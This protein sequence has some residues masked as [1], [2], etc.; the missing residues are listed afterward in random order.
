[1]LGVL[2][3]VGRG[4]FFGVKLIW[5]KIEKERQAERRAGKEK[6]HAESRSC[7]LQCYKITYE[8]DASVESHPCRRLQDVRMPIL[9]PSDH[10]SRWNVLADRLGA[11]ASFLCALHCALLPLVV[12]MLPA[13]GLG[14]LADHRFE[15]GF[16]VFAAVLA[17]VSLWLGYRRHQ[18]VHAFG[19]FVPGIVLLLVGAQLAVDEP[20]HL[21]AVLVTIGGSLVA[22]AHVANLWLAQRHVHDASC[23]H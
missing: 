9:E 18:R 8:P 13:L 10:P 3:A 21:H 15:R 2:P 5:K 7:V 12:A 22:F 16:V 1:M 19:I 4:W 14:F 11:S 23:V 6:R 17:S 20:A